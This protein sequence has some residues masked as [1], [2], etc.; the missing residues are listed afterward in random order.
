MVYNH[1]KG[2]IMATAIFYASD[3]GHTE[4]VAKQIAE[5]L[6]NIEIFDIANTSIKK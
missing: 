2:A 1:N 6:D 5:K 3:T 4:D